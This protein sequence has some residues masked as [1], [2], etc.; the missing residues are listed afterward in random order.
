[1]RKL[2][3]A[4]IRFLTYLDQH[5]D[6]VFDKTEAFRILKNDLGLDSKEAAHLYSVWYHSKGDKDYSEVEYDDENALVSFIR[7][8][9]SFSRNS[10][11]EEYLDLLYD[12]EYEKLEKIYGEWINIRCG[13]WRSSTP[14]IVWNDDYI[15]LELE[16]NE[17][18]EHFSGLYEQDL[19]IY[20]SIF[21]DYGS[22]YEE[23]SD[24]EFDYVYTNE[25]TEELF[26]TL[27]L[28]GGKNTWPGKDNKNIEQGEVS[29]FLEGILPTDKY[30]DIKNDYLT[31]VGYA[32]TRSRET[33]AKEEYKSE[34]K[35]NTD[36]AS[37]NS[38]SYC[39]E[40]PYDD[41][42]DIITE[43][44]LINLSEL[45]DAEIQPYVNLE[46]VYYESWVDDEQIETIKTEFNRTLSRI[47]D[48]IIE[49]DDIDLTEL[50]EKRQNFYKYIK[51]LGFVLV[52]QTNEKGDWYKSKDDK[53]HFYML[54]VDF[55]ND[56]IKFTYEGKS[57]LVPIENL[58][59]WVQGSVLDLNESVRY[60]K[61]K[62]L[63]EN[64][65]IVNK[66]S[67][68]D[69]DGTLMSTPHPEEGKVI[70]E[71]KTGTKYPHIGWW[72]KP[73]SLDTEIFDIKTIPPTVNAYEREKENPNTL[74]VMLTGRLPQQ[75]KQVEGLLSSNGIYFDEYHYKGNG[76][77]L[78][79]KLN[80]IRTLLIKYPTVESI[81]MWEDREPHAIEFRKWGKENGIPLKVNLVVKR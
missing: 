58:S 8:M 47:I 15:T 71:E 65:N 41:L 56:K 18:K 20:D 68:F 50:M 23:V 79:S 24:E 27:A 70:W 46:G 57:H 26:K 31:E 60:N 52:S 81:E 75:H 43:K 67:I 14:C 13:G 21:S 30:E 49:N 72:S 44:G 40:I 73:E 7:K 77:T 42:I 45:K 16:Y 2:N 17:W 80:T 33:A 22:D 62:L 4:E 10:E 5:L 37:C 19:Y 38:G 11:R 29:E 25:E 74:L 78:G 39:I 3:R 48:S 9:S 32:V 34:I 63:K 51:D 35:Y 6:D 59:D 28:I 64:K 36:D 61:T 12:D 66:I 76:D 55:E 53:I 54:D 69:F 1:M